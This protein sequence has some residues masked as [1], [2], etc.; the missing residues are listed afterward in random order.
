M[1]EAVRKTS[2]RVSSGFKKLCSSIFLLGTFN[3]KTHG[4]NVSDCT[5]CP[6]GKYCAGE[7]NEIWTNDC[8]PGF[9]CIGGADNAS[10]NDGTTGVICPTG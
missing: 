10:P 5:S 4:K 9:H 3:N 1:S 2:S 8:S 7:G 6:A